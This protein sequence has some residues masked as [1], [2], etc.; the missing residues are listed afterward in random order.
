MPALAVTSGQF[1]I[2]NWVTLAAVL[3]CFCFR[4]NRMFQDFAYAQRKALYI[5]LACCLVISPV[6]Q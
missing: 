3:F 4:V 6:W 1:T 2:I 5:S